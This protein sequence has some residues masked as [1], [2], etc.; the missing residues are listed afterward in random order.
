ME[1]GGWSSL[2]MPERY[3]H[4]TPTQKA[5]AVEGLVEEFHNAFHN[6]QDGDRQEK[7]IT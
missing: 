3:G 6:S 2:R 1:L 5:K 7:P 4:V